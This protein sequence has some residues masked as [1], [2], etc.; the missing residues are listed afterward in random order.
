MRR[1][2]K[3]MLIGA[4][5]L[6]IVPGVASAEVDEIHHFD[7]LAGL[8]GA[9]DAVIL[10]SAQAIREVDVGEGDSCRY[11]D[12]DIRVE[13]VLSNRRGPEPG[14]VALF[15]DLECGSGVAELVSEYQHRRAVFFGKSSDFRIPGHPGL[16]WI[17][18]I[19]AGHVHD[20][21]G[22]AHI[23][24]TLNAPFLARLEGS[25][26]A[27]FVSTVRGLAADL[28]PTDQASEPALEGAAT[29][30]APLW[31]L[32]TCVSIA[33]ALMLQRRRRAAPVATAGHEG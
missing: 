2:L 23:P 26:F 28:P 13:A 33:M 32:V 24:E 27:G 4:V 3:A 8:V 19:S 18:V 29:G 25:S 10:G 15:R 30:Q 5:C 11:V 20:V 14:K 16:H 1:W 7:S 31:V 21:R 17:P 6:A 22:K 9:A 12:V